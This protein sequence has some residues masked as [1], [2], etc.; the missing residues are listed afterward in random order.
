MTEPLRASAITW[1]QDADSNDDGGPQRFKAEIE[2]AG[3]GPFVVISS[4]RWAISDAAEIDLLAE[5]LKA[6]LR[7]AP[8]VA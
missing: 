6:F 8:E 4:E 7:Q 2:D 1:M 5:A 3:G